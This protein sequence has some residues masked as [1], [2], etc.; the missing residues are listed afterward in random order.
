MEL[1]GP[2][3]LLVLQ[4][5]PWQ[6]PVEISNSPAR[7]KAAA[8]YQTADIAFAWTHQLTLV[9]GSRK[10]LVK[11]YVEPVE[12][13]SQSVSLERGGQLREERAY[14]NSPQTR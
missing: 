10:V 14:T 7:T 13:K 4:N 11:E 8:Q 5:G 3:L 1:P 12:N 6:F 9:V 2:W